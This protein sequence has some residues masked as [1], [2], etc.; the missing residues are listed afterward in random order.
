MCQSRPKFQ[1]VVDHV[2]GNVNAA[3]EYLSCIRINPPTKI[4]T[5]SNSKIP[6]LNMGMQVP[7]NSLNSVHLDCEIFMTP[8]DLR[9]NLLILNAVYEQN[10]LDSFDLTDKQN[11]VNLRT[12]QQKDQD[13]VTTLQWLETG[14][15]PSSS[16]YLNSELM[17]YLKHFDSLENHNSFLYLKFQDHTGC[18]VL[19]QYVVTQ[20]MRK[21]VLYRGHISKRAGH[22]GISK[23]AT[24]FRQH[25]NF[26]TFVEF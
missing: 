17:I 26:F 21:E 7:D 5:R 2:S 25:F 12:E 24:L 10:P 20:H 8:N 16:H 11:P 4:Q 19:R 1:L 18:N 15:P 3:A 13:M 23:T 6:V 9:K 14:P 22:C